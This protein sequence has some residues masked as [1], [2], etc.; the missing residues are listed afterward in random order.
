MNPGTSFG[1]WLK[2]RRRSMDLTQPDLAK[3][4]GCSLETIV[5]IESGE[6]RPSKQV[7]ERL[8]ECLGVP[9]DEHAAFVKYAR[10]E[11]SGAPTAYGTL[12]PILLSQADDRTPWRALHSL[13][14]LY[15][16][17][18]NLP[19]Q[20]HAFIGPGQQVAA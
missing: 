14:R 2:A 20:P 19:A 8:A 15:A 18:N 7:A 13:H 1:L 10:A 5:K 4:V 16:Y 17:P 11:A 6:R 9:A 3:R 12:M